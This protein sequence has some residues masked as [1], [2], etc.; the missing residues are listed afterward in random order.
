MRGDE[1]VFDA[2]TGEYK[3]EEREWPDCPSGPRLKALSLDKLCV[4]LKAK[5]I[6]DNDDDIKG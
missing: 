6:I 1:I 3:R 2:K 5:G 4:K